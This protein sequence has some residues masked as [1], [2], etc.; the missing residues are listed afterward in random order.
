MM[1]N[2]SHDLIGFLSDTAILIP[3]PYI[4]RLQLISNYND[5]ISSTYITIIFLTVSMIP[6]SHS[7]FVALN[8]NVSQ[9][10]L[11]NLCRYSKTSE[12]PGSATAATV[13]LW[14]ES[15]SRHAAPSHSFQCLNDY[16]RYFN[17]K[18]MTSESLRRPFLQVGMARSPSTIE[19]GDIQVFRAS[20][21]R[22]L[23]AMSDKMKATKSNFEQMARFSRLRE[24]SKQLVE[25]ELYTRVEQA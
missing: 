12:F 20:I 13:S 14:R 18:G 17:V 23:P 2:I 24:T 5:S 9:G 7:K 21:D 1:S 3:S 19:A 6:R 11:Y 8:S 10:Q 25:I 4:S 22:Q 16:W 15:L